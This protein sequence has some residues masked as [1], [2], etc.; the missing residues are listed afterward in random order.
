MSSFEFLLPVNPNL[1]QLAEQAE[2]AVWSNPRTTLLQGRLFGEQLAALISQMEKVEPVY[3]IKQLERLHLLA[4]KDIISEIIRSSFEWLR[5]NGNAAAHDSKEIPSDLALSAHRHLY[6]LSAWYVETYGPLDVSIPEYRMPM[7]SHSGKEQE[8]GKPSQQELSVRLEQLLKDQLADKLLPS[9][10]ER[11]REMNELLLKFAGQMDAWA[12]KGTAHSLSSNMMDSDCKGVLINAEIEK[13]SFTQQEEKQ[14]IEI[15]DYLIDKSLSIVDKRDNGGALWVFGGW[16][17]KDILFALKGQGFYFRFAR[18]GS[19]STKRKPAWF[20][21]GKDPSERRYIS[22]VTASVIAVEDDRDGLEEEGTVEQQETLVLQSTKQDG[23]YETQTDH[24]EED[25]AEVK[26]ESATE[27]TVKVP[28]YLQWRRVDSYKPSRMSEIADSL[29]VTYFNDWS[30]DRLRELYRHQPKLLHDMLVQLWFYGFEFVGE[31]SRFIKLERSDEWTAVPSMITGLQLEHILTLDVVRQ[32]ERFG[33]RTTDQLIGLP[34]HSL[35]W[36]LRNRYEALQVA[37]Q[38]YVLNQT[39]EEAGDVVAQTEQSALTVRSAE[40]EIQIPAHL[41]EFPVKDLPINGCSALLNGI[42][43]NCNVSVLGDLP[44]DLSSLLQNIKGAGSGALEKMAKQLISFCSTHGE[45]EQDVSVSM[46]APQLIGQSANQ[47][48][49]LIWRDQIIEL[50][51]N[52]LAMPITA[53][54]YPSVKRITRYLEEQN[55]TSVGLLPS[56][57]D[58]LSNGESIGKTSTEKFVS[59]LLVRLEEYRLETRM[60][61]QF[62]AMSQTERIDYSL[63]RTVEK[64]AVKLTEEEIN[65]NRNLQILHSSWLERREGRK[66]TLEWLGQ[67]FSLTRERVRQIIPKVLRSFH[68]DVLGLEQV[69]KE[70]CMNHNSFYYYP[71]NVKDDFLHGLIEQVVE[72]FE[73]LIYLE[74]YGWWTTRSLDEVNQ[75]EEFLRQHLNTGLRGRVRDEETLRAI[76]DEALQ[77]DSPPSELAWKMVA[78]D[79]ATTT[80]GNYYLANS[81][82]WE[83]VEM[84]LRQFPEG[85]EVYKREEELMALAN[86]IKPGEYN[87]ERDFTSVFVRDDFLEDIAYLWGR[88]MFIHHEYVHVD[89]LLVQEISDKALDLLEKRSP[90]SVNRLFP[91]YEQRLQEGGI[92]TEYALYTMLRKLGSNKL[93]LN[94]FPHIWHSDDAFKLSNAE[95]IKVFI[96]EH[97][98]PITIEHLRDEFVGKRGWKRFTLEFSIQTDSDFVRTDLGVVGLRE[99]Y[100]YSSMDLAPIGDRLQELLSETGVIHVNRLFEVMQD[101]CASLGIRSSYLL[102]DLLKGIEEYMDKFRMIRY[103]LILSADHPAGELTLQTLVEQ[104]LEEQESEVAREVV[105]HW[106]TEEVGARAETLDLVLS[107]SKDIFFYQDGQFGEYIHRKSFDWT[108]EKENRLVGLVN[109][110]LSHLELHGFL[111]TTITNLMERLQLPKLVNDLVWTKDLLTD[112][113]RKSGDFQLLGS[114]N[115]IIVK[116]NHPLITC[117]TDWLTHILHSEFS[118]RVSRTN[119]HQR[120]AELKYSKDGKFLYETTVKLENGNAPF[121]VVDD[122]VILVELGQLS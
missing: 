15:A 121:L 49:R 29:G 14:E 90:I 38:P 65:N 115:H 86:I 54:E 62:E 50:S 117:E 48:K 25:E 10:D 28:S 122:D 12:Q 94:K 13:Q 7:P 113:L 98:E 108:D 111:Y 42:I 19:Q 4:R 34:E 99:F 23:D 102:Y 21:T 46:S 67:K 37:L 31:L 27:A 77:N 119:W 110:E 5:M 120:L 69:L 43:N 45:L 109:S 118:G 57:L 87:K 88:G 3:A 71:M 51:E 89:D 58:Q 47:S 112:C 32:L 114:Y 79:L 61:E 52:E 20:L 95:Q 2:Q 91:L 40:H 97:Y 30:E 9:I 55:I 60:R 22:T 56:I 78:S 16:E 66:A 73:G 85:V 96:R 63:Q 53:A 11:F 39:A 74:R 8:T 82:K 6:V 59:Q 76:I 44:Y 107:A 92:P 33:I 100:P 26:T 104:Y 64:L 83:I 80:E 116:Q 18:N 75:T 1:A 35:Q 72:E 41:L 17:L 105:Y 24:K 70:S 68:P 101:S 84:V 106:V 81:K 103:P 36:L 93:A